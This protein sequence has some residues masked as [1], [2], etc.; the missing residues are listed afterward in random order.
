MIERQFYATQFLGAGQTITALVPVA[1][2]TLVF[3]VNHSFV[4]RWSGPGFTAG[5]KRRVGQEIIER[6]LPEMAE[7]LGLCEGRAS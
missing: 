1:A 2:G 5:A 4:D 6:I 3:Y 7:A